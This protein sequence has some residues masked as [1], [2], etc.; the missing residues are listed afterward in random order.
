MTTHITTKP[1]KSILGDRAYYKPFDFPKAYDFYDESEKMHWL[2]SEV[3]LSQD[4]LDWNTK[5]STEEKQ[6]LTQL[7]RLFTQSDIDVAGAYA[8]KY[9]PMFK[10]PEIRMML[11]SFAAREAVHIQAYSHLIDTLGM[12]ETTY[13][14]FHEY[15]EMR[16]KH[17]YFEGLMGTDETQIVQQIA[18][19]SAFTEGVQLFSSFIMLL[20][21]SRFNKMN[22]MG[23]IILYSIKDEAVKAGTEVLTDTGWKVIEDISLSDKVYQYDMETK[24]SSFVNPTKTQKVVRDESYIFESDTIH[25]W[26]SPN[27]RMITVDGEVLAKDSTG[28]E[29]LVLNGNKGGDDELTAEDTLAIDMITS[30]EL[31]VQWIYDK[32]PFVSSTWAKS[33]VEYY[34]EKVK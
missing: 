2:A 5:L 27:H 12:P 11:L 9:L 25:Q 28:N 31:S 13:K 4:V 18:A 32:I 33:A 30:G 8:T 21:F 20:N 14:Q 17:D 3:P 22:G 15:A 26:V 24:E 29:L 23:T 16:E 19:F 34:L 10:L 1:K 7:F 6:F